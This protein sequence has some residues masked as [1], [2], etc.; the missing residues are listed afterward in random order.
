MSDVKPQI[1]YVNNAAGLPPSYESLLAEVE[2]LR[3]E[4]E[5]ANAREQREIAEFTA[6]YECAE[7]G[8]S[9]Y[10][11]PMS[12]EI[13]ENHWQIG[14]KAGAYERL[15]AESRKSWWRGFRAG[16]MALIDRLSK[17]AD[18]KP[19]LPNDHLWVLRK[20]ETGKGVLAELRCPK[21]KVEFYIKRKRL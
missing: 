10:E 1:Q 19:I 20:S 15:R 16:L 21:C 6:G 7:R 12:A 5:E 2:R 18:G 14:Y 8:G 4:L 17:T 9:I 3:K 11:E 13:V